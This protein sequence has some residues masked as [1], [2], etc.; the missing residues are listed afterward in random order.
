MARPQHS[1]IPADLQRPPNIDRG[2]RA[3]DQVY[4][5]LRRAILSLELPPGSPISEIDLAAVAAVSRT[6]VREAVKRLEQERLV[7]TFP[8]L[9]SFVSKINLQEIE[10][11]IVLRALLEGEAAARGA[12]LP[13]ETLS[14][15]L[16]RIVEQ[17]ERASDDRNLP[18]IYEADE[19]FHRCLFA[20][21]RLQLMWRSVRL[22]RT[23]MQRLR[24]ITTQVED[25]RRRSLR[26]HQAITD[27]IGR[28][29]AEEARALMSDHVRS[30]WTF[31]DRIPAD[32]QTFI[33][34]ANADLALAP[35]LAEQLS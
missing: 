13:D 1:A 15:R 30:N 32:K 20:G 21:T 4:A 19:S 9:G 7:V 16:A 34:A 18:A 5:W 11:S 22:A 28:H 3:S 27:A 26:S 2:Q 6:P 35:E 29:D 12:L 14:A 23:S 24:A 10:E 31:L 33:D 8:S 17:H 25:N